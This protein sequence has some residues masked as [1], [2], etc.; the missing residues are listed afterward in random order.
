MPK[1]ILIKLWSLDSLL[2]AIICLC[3]MGGQICKVVEYY[4]MT[5][6]LFCILQSGAANEVA[7]PAE[8]IPAFSADGKTVEVVFSFDTTGSMYGVLAQVNL[9]DI[10]SVANLLIFIIILLLLRFNLTYTQ[11]FP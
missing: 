7:D 11:I 10:S 6:R 8:V 3:V 9:L 2:I 5:S 1:F 4:T